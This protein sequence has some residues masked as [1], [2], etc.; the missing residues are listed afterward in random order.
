MHKV[1]LLNQ[2]WFASELRELGF[3]VK[4]A[5]HAFASHLE[6]TVEFPFIHIDSLFKLIGNNWIPDTIVA[7]DNSAPIAF[8]GLEETDIPTI[9]YSVDT[10]HHAGLHRFLANVFD[11]TMVAQKDYIP[12]F[13]EHGLTP[14]WFPLWASRF[15]E[16]SEEKKQGA[17]FIGTMN[18]ELNPQRVAFFE[19]LK[20]RVEI[21]C[22]MGEYWKIFPFSE[23]VVNQTVKL[24]LNFRVFES[25]MCGSLLLTERS[26]NGLF[27]LF[28]DGKHLITYE[29]NNVDEAAQKIK[30]YLENKEIARQIAK[31]GR[32]EIVLNHTPMARAKRM[33]EIILSTKK[34]NN[35]CRYYS[36]AVNHICLARTQ[37]N[38]EKGVRVSG[39]TIGLKC[40]ESGLSLGERF[41]ETLATQLAVGAHDFDKHMVS[42]SGYGL[43]KRFYQKYPESKVLAYMVLRGALN[44]GEKGL[45]EDISNSL[46]ILDLSRGYDEA[47]IVLRK[48]IDTL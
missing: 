6:T 36:M 42:S 10:H 27:D 18:A 8:S 3:D 43:M 33:S 35:P 30:Y 2:D 22:R 23:I 13:Q 5:G 7:L 39:L 38:I 4:T 12:F 26:N 16:A 21:D 14:E 44:V 25:M 1:L 24:D 17:V 47:D 41:D 37:K 29:K 32:D 31:T 19:E 15:V 9:F 46:G 20:K 11:H 45:A 28:D 34:T 48:L 40:F